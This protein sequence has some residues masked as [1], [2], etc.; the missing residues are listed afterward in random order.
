VTASLTVRGAVDADVEA[1][2]VLV[3]S[4]YRG[5]ASRAG[6]TTEADLLDGARTDA[7][8]LRADLADPA[9]TVL[10]ADA[11][12]L[13]ACCAV[14]RVG[15]GTASFGTF[16]VSPD[17]Q[18]GGLG[19]RMLAAAEA[20]ARAEG[21]TTMEMSVLAPRDDLIAWY[22][23]RGYTVTERTRAFPYG[24]ERYGRPRRDD[25]YFRVLTK[26]LVAGS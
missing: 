18:G 21:A 23:R 26:T 10:V 7:D 19:R 3:H 16:A 22:R 2:L 13:V 24:D 14:T 4:A 15:E 25:L 8:L 1:L 12:G 11:D 9:T 17:H 5:D 20:R 6:W